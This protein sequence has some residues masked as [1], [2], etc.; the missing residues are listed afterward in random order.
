MVRLCTIAG[1]EDV[2][3]PSKTSSGNIEGKGLLDRLIYV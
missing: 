2:R 1:M 3:N